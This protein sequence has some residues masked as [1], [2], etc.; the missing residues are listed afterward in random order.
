MKFKFIAI[1]SIIVAFI[2]LLASCNGDD[3]SSHNNTFNG[4]YSYYRTLTAP[5][6]AS[7]TP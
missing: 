3:D 5:I 7:M 6:V 1:T 4:N 2:T